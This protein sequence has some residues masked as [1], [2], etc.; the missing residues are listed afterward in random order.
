[1][2]YKRDGNGEII[3]SRWHRLIQDYER[4]L[5]RQLVTAARGE[6]RDAAQLVELHPNSFDQIIR[7]LDMRAEVRAIRERFRNNG[8]GRRRNSEQETG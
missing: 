3:Y 8:T 2:P 6:L 7:R 5:I 4:D 1:M